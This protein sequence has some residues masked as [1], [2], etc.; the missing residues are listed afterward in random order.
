MSSS[1]SAKSGCDRLGLIAF[2][3]G[4][5]ITIWFP[6]FFLL[7][8]QQSTDTSS[9]SDCLFISIMADALPLYLPPLQQTRCPGPVFLFIFLYLVSLSSPLL[10]SRRPVS[11]SHRR[12]GRVL[13]FNSPFCTAT[14]LR[15]IT[16]FSFLVLPPLHSHFSLL[17]LFSVKRSPLDICVPAEALA[18]ITKK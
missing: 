8:S 14:L 3:K 16:S 9:L 2:N 6:F 17:F 13:L 1:Q 10:S 5:A 18:T 12:R 4:A 15:P 11:P 7:P